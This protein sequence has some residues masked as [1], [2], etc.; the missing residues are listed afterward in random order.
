[1][2][3]SLGEDAGEDL[4]R[5]HFRLLRQSVADAGGDEV[6]NLGDGLMVA[7][8]SAVRAL[9]CAIAM[10]RAIDRHN[11][12]ADRDVRPPR[13]TRRPARRRGDPRRRTTTSERRS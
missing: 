11:R 4:R 6:K 8:V 13:G 5:V 2:L 7:F 3:D 10:Q 12:M 9:D 1:M